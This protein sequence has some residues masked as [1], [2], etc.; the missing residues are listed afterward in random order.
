[1]TEAE[2]KRLAE[3]LAYLYGR[4][5]DEKEYEDF[6]DYKKALL[7]KLPAGSTVDRF[8]KSPFRVE[9]S[10]PGQ[11]KRYMRVK[12]NAVLFGR[13]IRNLLLHGEARIETF[14]YTAEPEGEGGRCFG[15][16]G[17]YWWACSPG[18]LPDG[19]PCGPFDTEEEALDHA[20]QEG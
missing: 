3:F 5:Q 17:W 4:W 6:A 10:V 2:T 20:T 12:G 11:P 9:F 19:D 15:G 13:L 18:C 7:G 14:F 16:T 8:T 1:M